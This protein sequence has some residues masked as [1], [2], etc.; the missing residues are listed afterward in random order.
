MK[1]K[2][3]I[4][5]M[6]VAFLMVGCEPLKV[7]IPNREIEGELKVIRVAANEYFLGTPLVYI[8]EHNLDEAYGLKIELSVYPSGVQENEALARGEVDV[9]LIG[10]AFVFGVVESNAKVIGEYIYSKGGNAI[11]AH[12]KSEIFNV[13][14]FNPT[15]P[16]VYGNRDTVMDKEILLEMGTTAQLLTFRWLE[17]IGVKNEDVVL[18]DMDFSSS[19]KTFISGE[20]DIAALVSPYSFLAEELGYKKIAS[21][22]ELN[23]PFYEVIIASEE[24]YENRK[25]DLATFLEL[26]FL[27]NDV[28]ESKTSTKHDYVMK[29]YEEAG[30]P[31]S[32]KLVKSESREKIFITSEEAKNLKMGVFEKKYALFMAQIGNLNAQ[33][34]EIVEENVKTDI[35][36]I[37]LDNMDK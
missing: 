17:T 33:Q 25:E 24:A 32:Y 11:Y 27:T 34:V 15:Y 36:D 16:E 31:N 22:E 4:T 14:G 1:V 26:I 21:F 19:Y 9:A 37:A 13:K 20:G 12:K 6:I 30:N 8:M 5:L 29:W 35:L 7:P 10:G 3:I 2:I 28:L 18:K 23:Y